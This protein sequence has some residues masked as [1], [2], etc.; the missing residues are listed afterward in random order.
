MP[1]HRR[2]YHFSPSHITHTDKEAPSHHRVI[3]FLSLLISLAKLTLSYMAQSPD[4]PSIF[5]L[6]HLRRRNIL[7]SP[8]QAF[9]SLTAASRPDTPLQAY[10]IHILTDL[11]VTDMPQVQRQILHLPHENPKMKAAF[12]RAYMLTAPDNPGSTQG[13]CLQPSPP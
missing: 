4:M 11:A 5:V 6:F 1:H 9:P 3:P 13:D 7:V 2:G 8:C 12:S 10:R